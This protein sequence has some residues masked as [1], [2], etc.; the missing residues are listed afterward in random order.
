MANIEAYQQAFPNLLEIRRET[1]YQT[2]DIRL[3]ATEELPDV[4]ELCTAFL[5]DSEEEEQILIKDVINHVLENR[6]SR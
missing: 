4:Y 3:I 6:G 5:S 2:E 1:F